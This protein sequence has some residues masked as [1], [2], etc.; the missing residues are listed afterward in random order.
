MLETP[1]AK[2]CRRYQLEWASGDVPE[3]LAIYG[4]EI[5]R[6]R[7]SPP[8]RRRRT[9][10]PGPSRYDPTSPPGETESIAASPN[11]W[12]RRALVRGRSDRPPTPPIPAPPIPPP[13]RP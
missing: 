4:L 9:R 1:G 6:C 2:D 3:Y 7:D 5:P 12:R 13:I 10:A 8:G 11:P